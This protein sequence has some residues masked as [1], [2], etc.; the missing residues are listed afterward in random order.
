VHRRAR[1]S[2]ASAGSAA[3]GSSLELCDE[4]R[5]RHVLGLGDISTL[6]AELQQR[7]RVQCLRA[8]KA[9]SRSARSTDSLT[10][11]AVHR[12]PGLLQTNGGHPSLSD[13]KLHFDSKQL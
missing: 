6:F 8:P 2:R 13:G 7:L 5:W 9:A 1:R 12:R 3:H 11:V 10:V 4:R